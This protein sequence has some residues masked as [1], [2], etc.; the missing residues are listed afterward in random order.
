[1]QEINDFDAE[2]KARM[3]WIQYKRREIL[4]DDYTNV[5]PEQFG[6]LVKRILNLTIQS[7]KKDILLIVDVTD[8]F[9]NK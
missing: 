8:A 5:M 3:K 1:M 4:L 6:P 2:A 7:G 9:A